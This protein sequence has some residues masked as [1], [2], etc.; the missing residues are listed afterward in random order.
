MVDPSHGTGKKSMII[1][2]AKAAIAAGA[3][4]VMVDVHDR[5][6]EALC[7]GPQAIHPDEFAAMVGTLRKLAG[8]LDL[9]I[10]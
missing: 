5:P 7:D 2:M 8:A 4:A 6:K 9:E 3:N 10:Q 1:P